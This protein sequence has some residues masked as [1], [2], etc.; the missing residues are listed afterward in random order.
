M[1]PVSKLKR[2]F[3]ETLND[4][5]NLYNHCFN[6]VAAH[7][8]PGVE[9]AFLQLFKGWESLLEECTLA[10]M[11]GRLRVDGRQVQNDINI[12]TELI[13][14]KVLYASRAFVE[15]TDVEH[16][17]DR[18]NYLFT[19]ANMLTVALRPSKPALKQMTAVRNAIAHSSPT[20]G[21][22]FL[23]VVQ[24]EFGG[25]P[26]IGRPAQLLTANCRHDAAITYFDYYADILE[27]TALQITG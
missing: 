8:E 23:E 7:T 11:C 1:P 17:L 6:P 22:K 5:R 18:W 4:C 26:P 24:N 15:W 14:R 2:V 20:A 9:A 21:K 25:R 19:S 16:V 13:A 10:F 12:S 3:G 27:T